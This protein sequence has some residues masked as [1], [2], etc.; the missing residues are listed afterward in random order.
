M[1]YTPINW[2]TGDTITADKLNKMDNGW[3]AQNNSVTYYSGSITTENWGNYSGAEDIDIDN[4]ITAESITVTFDDVTYNVTASSDGDYGAPHNGNDDVY[5]FTSIPFNISSNTNP[6]TGVTSM[7]F[8]T[9]SDGTYDVVIQS[10]DVSID[11][12]ADFSKAVSAVIGGAFYPLVIGT[13]TW[14]Q[15]VDAMA[16]GKLVLRSWAN[17]YDG[18][19]STDTQYAGIELVTDA[20]IDARGDYRVSAIVVQKGV[21]SVSSYVASNADEVL[22]SS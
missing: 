15:V 4:E 18:S 1:A 11:T 2:K 14:S 10:I 19:T 17:A 5:D 22:T 20:Y 3:E 6:I 8:V 16:T 9:Q 21:Q 7:T 13:T 12:S